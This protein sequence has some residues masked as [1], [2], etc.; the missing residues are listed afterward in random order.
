MSAGD[1]RA[2]LA[3]AAVLVPLWIVLALCCHWEPVVRDGWGH[4]RWH[5]WTG[6]SLESLW[7][8]VEGGYLHNNPRLG[9]VVTTLQYTPGPWHV[10]F[11]PLLELAMFALLTTLVL[12]RRPSLRSTGDALVFATVTGMVVT[13][14]PIVG[15]ILFYRPYTGNYLFGFAMQL[16]FLVPYR[17][18][19]ERAVN[20]PGGP[21]TWWRVPAMVVLGAAA[22]MCNEHTPPAVGAAALV[23]VIACWRR[24]DRAA[25]AWM[26][27][28]LVG[29]AIGWLALIYAPGQEFRYNALATQAS[30]LDRI[31]DRGAAGD[32]W[33]IFRT[34][35]Y[36]GWSVPWL[37]LGAI[38]RRRVPSSPAVSRARHRVVLVGL[39]AAVLAAVTL[40]GSP[41]EGERLG[42]AS[43]ALAA[44]AIA[45]WVTAQ[46]APGWSRRACAVMA[47]VAIAF[48]CARCLYALHEVSGEFDDRLAAILDAPKD[49][50]VV[51]H[52]Y[53]V[54]RSRW[55]LGD[56]FVAPNARQYVADTFGVG[57]IDLAPA[58]IEP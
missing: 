47:A 39:G 6:L 53:T 50:T 52:A 49:A 33:I 11:T 35:M 58:R 38:A 14:I 32:A 40:L 9:Q 45:S 56:D 22:G 12:G 57:H 5:R 24:G 10:L 46:L 31:A 1:K 28:G 18:R 48:V 30:T 34:L 43:C 26:L 42:F 55:F 41:K 54:P 29:I 51:V 21:R 17:L 27:A 19:A 25:L 20:A 7:H 44:T 2:R 36:L 23:A 37:V 3:W 15:Q 13:C 4:V 8:A 16:A